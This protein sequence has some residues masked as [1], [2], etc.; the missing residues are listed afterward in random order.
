MLGILIFCFL[1][2]FETQIYSALIGCLYFFLVFREIMRFYFFVFC[3]LKFFSDPDISVSLGL[4]F[5]TPYSMNVHGSY[6]YTLISYPCLHYFYFL[7]SSF[8]RLF[9]LI[10]KELFEYQPK[11]CQNLVTKKLITVFRSES[12]DKFLNDKNFYEIHPK[13]LHELNINKPSAEELTEYQPK[14]FQAFKQ[15][16]RQVITDISG[17]S[18]L[19]LSIPKELEEENYLP[20]NCF[21][22]NKMDEGK[23]SLKD[24]F[25]KTADAS[26]TFNIAITGWFPR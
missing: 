6:F 5:Y 10:C 26:R 17:E 4:G 19:I 3:R 18:N 16:S 22:N 15:E 12:F 24:L 1:I 13:K 9:R 14:K 21:L 2:F 7:L 20:A 23:K 8:F 11:K 25:K